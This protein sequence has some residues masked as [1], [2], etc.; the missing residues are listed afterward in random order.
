M[1]TP[2]A[3]I[4]LLLIFS[5]ASLA[6]QHKEYSAKEEGA[7]VIA[8]REAAA[9]EQAAMAREQ[10]LVDAERRKDAAALLAFLADDFLEI[11]VEGNLVRKPDVALRLAGIEEIT[12]MSTSGMQA[13]LIAD[14]VVLVTY[15][16]VAKV[17]YQGRPIAARAAVSSVWARRQGKWLLVFH[18]GTPLPEPPRP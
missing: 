9:E 13:H 18:Q 17:T 8:A 1:R 6:Q 15:T 5:A 4:A 11:G 2:G 7:R 16:G 12:E 3:V 14:D 10:Q